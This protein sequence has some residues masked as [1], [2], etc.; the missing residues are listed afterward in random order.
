MFTSKPKLSKYLRL[1]I[2]KF[3][4]F[5]RVVLQKIMVINR[6]ERT[7]IVETCLNTDNFFPQNSRSFEFLMMKQ[8]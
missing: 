8:T 1:E 2:Y 3:L 6:S 7:F 5:K 4:H